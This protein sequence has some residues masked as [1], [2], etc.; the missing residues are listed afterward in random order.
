MEALARHPN[1]HVKVSEFGLKDQPWDFESNRRVVHD[2]IAIFGIER[3]MFGSDTPVSGLRIAFDPLVRSMKRMV[4]H[5]PAQDQ[6]RFF[7]RNA[8]AF[9]RMGR[10]ADP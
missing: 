4:A 8:Q 6:D 9:Y 3:C 10:S 1:V 2:A 7:R 5:L